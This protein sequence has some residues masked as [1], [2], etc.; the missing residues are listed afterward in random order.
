M[1]VG[2]AGTGIYIPYYYIKRETIA[3]QWD[4]RAA[5]GV[6]SLC[7]ADED[8]VT[9]PA[10]AVVIGSENV[11]ASIEAWE[12]VNV[13]IHDA[14]RNRKDDYVRTGESRFVRSKGYTYAL[15]EAMKAVMSS[16]NLCPNDI[17]RVILPTSNVKEQL[18]A[19]KAAGFAPEQVQDSLLMQVGDCGTAQPALLLAAALENAGPGEWILWTSYGSGA[20]AI[21]LKVTEKIETMKKNSFRNIWIPGRS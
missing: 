14:W 20:D 2:I 19:A 12:T 17:F 21:L 6:R 8:S 5:R 18:S 11:A 1:E 10:E 9:M 15:V 16:R 3:A 4:A 13:E 7:N